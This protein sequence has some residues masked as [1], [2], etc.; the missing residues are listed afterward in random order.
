[1]TKIFFEERLDCGLSLEAFGRGT[2]FAKLKTHSIQREYK[3]VSKITACATS[4]NLHEMRDELLLVPETTRLAYG[5]VIAVVP[6]TVS[7]DKDDFK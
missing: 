4:S 3:N 5:C 6:N 7:G 1:M 2:S